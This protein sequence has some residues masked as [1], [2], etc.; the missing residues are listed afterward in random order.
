MRG[1]L[2]AAAVVALGLLLAAC[3]ST[4]S[5]RPSPSPSS[6]TPGSTAPPTSSPTPSPTTSANPTPAQSGSP[7]A[8]ATDQLSAALSNGEGA[9]GSVIFA[10]EFKNTSAT[11]CTL[12]GN[13]GVSMVAGADGTQIGAAAT[14]VNRSA[15]TTVTLQPG[16][17]VAASLQIAEALN[18]PSSDCDVTSVLGLRVYPPGQTAALFISDSHLQGCRDASAK[19]MRVGPVLS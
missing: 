11:P 10:L 15:A 16:Q 2:A 14:F 19:L 6:A 13:P 9:A 4:A 7:T 17:Q 12:Y 8:C 5:H 1:T 18:Y 3:G